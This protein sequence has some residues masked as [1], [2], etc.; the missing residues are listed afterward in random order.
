MIK[1]NIFMMFKDI[2]YAIYEK[3]YKKSYKGSIEDFFKFSLNYFM[4][5]EIIIDKLLSQVQREINILNYHQFC[6]DNIELN[7][8]SCEMRLNLY[9]KTKLP[10]NGFYSMNKN[11]DE[12]LQ[13]LEKLTSSGDADVYKTDNYVFVVKPGSEHTIINIIHSNFVGLIATNNLRS[14]IPNFAYVIGGLQC[15]NNQ[16]KLLCDKTKINPKTII[17]EF[18]N[19]KDSYDFMRDN[20]LFKGYISTL[21]QIF[22]ALNTAYNIYDY[23]HYDLHGGNIIYTKLTEQV[24]IKY[25][26]SKGDVYIKSNVIISIID[27]EYTHIKYKGESYGKYSLEEFSIFP[28]KSFPLADIITYLIS[29][30]MDSIEFQVE[31]SIESPLQNI[32]INIFEN[33]I[34]KVLPEYKG[35]EL[36]GGDIF[37]GSSAKLN[38]KNIVSD[39]EDNKQKILNFTYEDA[40]DIINK[41]YPGNIS[42]IPYPNVIFIDSKTTKFNKNYILS[43]NHKLTISNLPDNGNIILKDPAAY[44]NRFV[45]SNQGM[46]D[47][48]EEMIISIPPNVVEKIDNMG[49]LIDN[50]NNLNYYKLASFGIQTSRN[51]K[52]HKKIYDKLF[53]RR[54]IKTT[55]LS[56]NE[57]REGGTNIESKINNILYLLNKT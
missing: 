40:F 44:H 50:K 14:L 33:I 52:F 28:D 13:N 3:R 30:I 12:R 47:E 39:N 41:L 23:C 24:C 17:Q 31:T 53:M 29:A 56:S 26:T 18:I 57:I 6:K 19:G 37:D 10:K 35:I 42:K 1:K 48:Y 11:I 5:N 45:Y 2:Y 21:F 7:I 34:N 4:L 27:H 49:K 43:G 51:W 38:Y 8:I 20:L 32:Y 15:S 25:K 55:K 54:K 36:S 9:D 22:L 16:S 46:K